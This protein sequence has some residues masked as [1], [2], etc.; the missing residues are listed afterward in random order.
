MLKSSLIF[1]RLLGHPCPA[2][3]C[4]ITDGA[5]VSGKQSN[6]AFFRLFA[7]AFCF[8]SKTDY[9]IRVIDGL[10]SSFI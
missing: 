8:G 1:S 2:I 7:S 5:V 4:N 6:F 3:G 10:F 9:V